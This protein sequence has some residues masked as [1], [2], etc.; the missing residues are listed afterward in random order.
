WRQRHHELVV[1]AGGGGEGSGTPAE[2]TSAGGRDRKAR[3]LDLDRHAAR[4]AEVAR[5]LEDTVAHV[6]HRVRDAGELARSAQALRGKPQT[7][8]PPGGGAPNRETC[9]TD[10]PGKVE[11][12]PAAAR[13]P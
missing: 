11:G 6:D 7:P 2:R 8:P 4:P 12:R 5:I 9:A 13:R 1:L 10:G 3:E